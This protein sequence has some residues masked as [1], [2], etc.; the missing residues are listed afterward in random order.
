MDNEELIR[1]IIGAAIA[2][3][4]ELGPGFLE[5]IYEAALCMELER[6]GILFERQK[7]VNILFRGKVIGE[8]RLDLLVEK[9]VIVENKAVLAMDK[10][11]FS[12]VRSYLKAAN[13]KD[14]LLLNFAAMPLTIKRVGSEDAHRY[15]EAGD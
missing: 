11:F 15:L 5:S 2:V 3:H 1:R 4:K 12:I 9:T 8:H 10:I 6:L 13:L 7:T 14:A